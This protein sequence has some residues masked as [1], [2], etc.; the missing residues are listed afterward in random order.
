MPDQAGLAKVKPMEI[1][2]DEPY[3]CLMIDENG[4]YFMS[5]VHFTNI[6]ANR[7]LDRFPALKEMETVPE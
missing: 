1:S 3:K 4:S 6:G 5:G 7:I 2:G